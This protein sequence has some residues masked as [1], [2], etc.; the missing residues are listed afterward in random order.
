[1]KLT[2]QWAMRAHIGRHGVMSPSRWCLW[3][4]WRSPVGTRVRA[5]SRGVL[6]LGHHCELDLI[7]G[8]LSEWGPAPL[9][10]DSPLLLGWHKQCSF[11]GWEPEFTELWNTGVFKLINLH[12]DAH[13]ISTHANTN[14]SGFNSI[15]MW[16]RCLYKLTWI[17]ICIHLTLSLHIPKL[18]NSKM[19]ILLRC[20]ARGIP[21][22]ASG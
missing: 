18:C 3:W 5:H 19:L 13:M 6:F 16:I 8:L 7:Q 22:Q 21:W 15:G 11:L 10:W 2:Y 20:I 1:M 4:S 9:A 14:P 12:A 17:A